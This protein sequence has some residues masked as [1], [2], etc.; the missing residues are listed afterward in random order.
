LIRTA[1]I[2]SEK[3]IKRDREK[4]LMDDLENKLIEKLDKKTLQAQEHLKKEILSEIRKILKEGNF[5]VVKI[6]N[7]PPSIDN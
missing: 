2:L 1:N 7:N 5:K 4:E 6:K 3:Y